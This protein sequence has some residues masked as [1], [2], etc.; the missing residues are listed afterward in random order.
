MQEAFQ[1]E[2]KFM[3][4]LNDPNVVRLVGV[5]RG[6]TPFILMEYME[7]GDLNQYLQKFSEVIPTG[8]ISGEGQIATSTLLYVSTQ[9]AS[10]MK[11]LASQNVVHRD[12]ATRNCLV[13]KDFTVKVADFGM[14]RNLYESHYYRIQGRAI[15]PVRWMASECFYGNFSQKTDVWAFGVTIW[16]VFELARVQP[17][18]DL[19][20]QEVIQDSIKGAERTLLSKPIACPQDVYQ[21]MLRC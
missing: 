15:L 1:K 2:L 21:I 11:Y 3:G 16:E 6:E 4:R 18:N 5:C 17:H 9:I 13:G 20:E 19:N 8:G 10:G 12:L 7:Q 14:S